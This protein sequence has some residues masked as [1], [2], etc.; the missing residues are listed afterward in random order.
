MSL[1]RLG[2]TSLWLDETFTWWFASMPWRKLLESVRID[3]VNP[4]I[5]YIVVKALTTPIGLNELSLRLL[6]I[7]ANMLAILF[8]MVIG[9]QIGG[10]A[11]SLASGWFWAFHPMALWYARDARPYS[12]TAALA[13][14]LMV[15][16][17]IVRRRSSSTALAFALITLTIGLLSH[18]FFFVFAASL[19]CLTLA[20]L[21]QKPTFFRRWT[22]TTLMSFVPLTLWLFWYFTQPQPSLGIG[23]IQTPK[24]S[25]LPATLW[26][27]LSGYGGVVSWPSNLFGG[28]VSLLVAVALINDR[29]DRP[30]WR[31]LIIGI[32][33]PLGAVWLISQRRP[34]YHDRYFIVLLPMVLILV[35]SGAKYI[36]HEVKRRY[37]LIN[38]TLL[39]A[40]IIL[41]FGGF[42]L[43][44]SWQVH[45]D[46]KF[47]KE[48]WRELTEILKQNTAERTSIMLSAPDT[49]LP[50]TYYGIDEIDP[51]FIKD[52]S[53]CDPDC[54]WI[55]RQPYTAT[56]AFSQ[57]IKQTGRSWEP[58][59]PEDC[60]IT[61]QWDSSTGLSLWHVRCR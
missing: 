16:F 6:S 34:V 58:E 41:C 49:L 54:W 33:L 7:L 15:L 26:N 22:L 37:T 18:Y 55:L 32:I 48:N 50:L 36:W 31:T 8:A 12:L 11:G 43:C 30:N 38:R 42:G 51:I 53:L 39:S 47:A 19:I 29:V 40:G 2:V 44:S 23:W 13:T 3:G 27:L 60:T 20:D 35:S 59:L 1:Y 9:Y 17:I 25:D 4:P 46:G 57:V 21:R 10:Y 28:L 56:H 61:D 5:Y 45:S 14:G 52:I 24:L